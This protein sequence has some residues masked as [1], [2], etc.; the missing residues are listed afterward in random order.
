MAQKVTIKTLQAMKRRSEKIC[1]LTAYDY[2]TAKHMDA[3]GI[4]VILVGD[5]AAMVFVGYE[6]TLPITMEEM[7]YHVKA[8]NRGC[9][10]ALLV[11]DM[12]FLSY[13]VSDELAI[14]NAGRMLK[15]G[16]AEA[17]KLEGGRHCAELIEKLTTIGIP[18]MGHVGMTPQ[19]MHQFGGFKLQGKN[20]KSAHKMANDAIALQKA[21]C[22]AIVLEKIPLELAKKISE[23]LTIPTIGIGAGPYC[24]G[25]V[26]VVSDMLGIYDE[27]EP[28]FLKKYADLSQIMKEAFTDYINEV[29][30][31]KFPTVEHSFRA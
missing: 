27:F 29:K 1:M 13:Q 23:S 28:K 7:L 11:A 24:D 17:V 21:G 8:A 31:G 6:S 22:F 3:A 16:G 5:S 18:V 12:P 26:L 2:L 9:S 19:S 20:E 25:Q 4:D 14:H 30:Q 15:D 10:R